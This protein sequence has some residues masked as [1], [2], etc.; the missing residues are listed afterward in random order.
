MA[1]KLMRACPASI[2]HTQKRYEKALEKKENYLNSTQ[3]ILKAQP[4]TFT[5]KYP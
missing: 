4:L 1:I 3:K 2:K 5:Q